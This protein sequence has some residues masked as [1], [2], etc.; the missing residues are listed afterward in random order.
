MISQT[1]FDQLV[2]T[3]SKY[4]WVLRRVVVAQDTPAPNAVAADVEIRPGVVDA[5]WFSRTPAEGAIPWEIRYLGPTQYALVEHVDEDAPDF[6]EKLRTVE[7]R[8]AEAVA[9]QRFA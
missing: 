3:Y 8:L 5:A 6:E 4:Q 1:E 7:G 2:A 9:A